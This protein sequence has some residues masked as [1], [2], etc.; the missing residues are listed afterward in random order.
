[1]DDYDNIQSANIN[2]LW[3]QNIY[4]NLR[5]LQAYERLAREGCMSIIEYIQ[6]PWEKKQIYLNDVQFKN[7]KFIGTEM[8]ILLVDLTPI[9]DAKDLDKF[10]KQL[11]NM[12]KVINLRKLFIKEF[13]S[14]IKKEVTKSEMTPFFYETLNLFI[15]LRSDIINSISHVL[16]VKQE[17][18]NTKKW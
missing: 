6:V 4:E 1:M 15:K 10:Q 14:G 3:L 2:A 17:D 13:F 18:Q 11:D 5:N 16:Y 7:L 12:N 9:M 8:Q